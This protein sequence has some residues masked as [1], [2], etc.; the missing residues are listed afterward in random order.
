MDKRP[1]RVV[2]NERKLNPAGIA[3]VTRR[4]IRKALM[5]AKI[6]T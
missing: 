1:S 4:N 3:S 2:D 6:M 5:A